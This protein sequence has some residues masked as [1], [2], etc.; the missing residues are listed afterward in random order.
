VYVAVDRRPVGYTIV[1]PG[2]ESTAYLPELAVARDRQREGY[3]SA[4]LEYVCGEL[5]ADG[6]RELRLSVLA[7]D[8]RAGQFYADRG[9]E[10]IERL[11]DEF[12]RGDGV[13]LARDLGAE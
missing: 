5:A 3:G 1:I 13:L 12:E 10:R 9:F 6:Y 8:E 2:P 11:P 7:G 4:L